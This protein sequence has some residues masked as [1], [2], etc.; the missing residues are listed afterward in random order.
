MPM[1]F[2][3]I[4]NSYAD[5]RDSRHIEWEELI[6][7]FPLLKD[8]MKPPTEG[9][10]KVTTSVHCECTIA[11]HMLRKFLE[12][13]N[14]VH[15][16]RPKFIGIGISKYSCWLCEKYIEFLVQSNAFVRFTVAG[17]QGK[18]QSGWKPPSHGP[19]SARSS[20]TELLK[21]EMDEILDTVE[22]KR[23]SDSFPRGSAPEKATVDYKWK[24]DKP[25][26]GLY[27]KS[28]S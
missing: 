14:T 6:N 28:L 21:H 5:I 19:P 23:R 4:V 20:M 8:E 26:P 11:V 18:I 13:Q 15:R 16:T 2:L 9:E 12:R 7:A 10:T 25:R 27:F 1:N 24:A 22:R 3:H 17:Y